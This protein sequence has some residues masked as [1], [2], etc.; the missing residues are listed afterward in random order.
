MKNVVS[1]TLTYMRH[2]HVS[3]F[4]MVLPSP[5]KVIPH[6]VLFEIQPCQERIENDRHLRV[7]L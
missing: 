6:M 7:H 3:W 2:I 5:V 4:Y 1:A